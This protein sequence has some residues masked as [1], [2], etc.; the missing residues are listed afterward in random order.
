MYYVKKIINSNHKA[1]V[2]TNCSISPQNDILSGS[3]VNSLLNH[4]TKEQKDVKI[5]TRNFSA[6]KC[7]F[8]KATKLVRN[9]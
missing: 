7:I 1:P 4:S 9:R 6:K 2:L 8:E 5:W 3:S